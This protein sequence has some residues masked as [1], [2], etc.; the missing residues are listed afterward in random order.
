LNQQIELGK[1]QSSRRQLFYDKIMRK[2]K[3][4]KVYN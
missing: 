2:Y 4:A 3:N 1:Y